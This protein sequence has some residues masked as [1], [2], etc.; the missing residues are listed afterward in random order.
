MLM[1]GSDGRS[2]STLT[3]IVLSYQTVHSENF[4]IQILVLSSLRQY[5]SVT[6]DFQFEKINF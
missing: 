2:D 5:S 1:C 4:L 3:R 6:E